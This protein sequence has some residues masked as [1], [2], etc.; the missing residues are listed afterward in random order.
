MNQGKPGEIY[1]ACDGHPGTMTDYFKKVARKAGL[2]SP[3][4]ISLQEGNDKLSEGMMSYMRES[5][6]LRNEKTLRELDI[7]LNYPTLEEG[8]EHC[9]L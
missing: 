8:L 3:P 1:H 4:E 7:K 9:D 6:R 5:R 2:G